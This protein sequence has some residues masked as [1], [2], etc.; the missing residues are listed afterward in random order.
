MDEP[1]AGAFIISCL[2]RPVVRLPEVAVCLLVAMDKV[3]F[4]VSGGLGSWATEVAGDPLAL[5]PRLPKGYRQQRD[6]M[7]R[8]RVFAGG[9]VQC[10]C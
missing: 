6:S 4:F 8:S 10:G 5:I 9:L 1:Q 2:E 7:E 3:A